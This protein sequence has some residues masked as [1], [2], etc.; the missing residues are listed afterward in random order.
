M[1]TTTKKEGKNQKEGKKQKWNQWKRKK[2]KTE[3]TNPGLEDYDQ[4]EEGCWSNM[5]IDQATRY[6]SC[7]IINHLQDVMCSMQLIYL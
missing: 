1:L 7:A 6:V 2:K 3:K 4:R 5:I